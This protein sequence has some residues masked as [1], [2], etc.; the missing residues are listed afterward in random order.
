MNE[1]KKLIVD[2]K[3]FLESNDLTNTP[4][5]QNL[6]AQYRQKIQEFNEQAEQCQK[7][8]ERNMFIEAEQ[9]ASS[10]SK[11][12]FQQQKI[13]DFLHKEEFEELFRMYEWGELPTLRC[14]VLDALKNQQSEVSELLPLLEMYRRVARSNDDRTKIMLLRKITRIDTGKTEWFN[15]LKALENKRI[16]TLTAE[17]K[18]AIIGKDYD[19]LEVIR[20]ELVSPGWSVSVNPLV[21]GK[22]AAVLQEKHEADLK[23]QAESYINN[24]NLAYSAQDYAGLAKA[25]NTW[26]SFIV[27]TNYQPDA[28]QLA[29]YK[30]AERYYLEQKSDYEQKQLA[31]SLLQQLEYGIKNQINHLELENVYNQLRSCDAEIPEEMERDF[32]EYHTAAEAASRRKTFL[33]AGAAALGIII[34][35]VIIFLICS[36]LIL[37]HQEKKWFTVINQSL[38]Q[39][40]SADTLSIIETLKT[41]YPRIAQRERILDLEKQTLA[42]QAQERLN[43]VKFKRVAADQRE[44][45]KNFIANINR[46]SKNRNDMRLLI[47][48]QQEESVYNQLDAVYQSEMLKL[49]NQKEQKYLAVIEQIKAG[50]R[51]F[52]VA[53]SEKN[54][55]QA[56]EEIEKVERLKSGANA[57]EGISPDLLVRS[58]RVLAATVEMN[59]LLSAEKE[60]F[61]QISSGLNRIYDAASHEALIMCINE[62]V[63]QY[64]EHP[65]VGRIKNLQEFMKNISKF[66]AGAENA[67]GSVYRS[68]HV[69][70]N[71]ILTNSKNILA[72][73]QKTFKDLNAFYTKKSLGCI[74]VSKMG[75]P[76]EFYYRKK[77]GISMPSI[78]D[79]QIGED[80]IQQFNFFLKGKQEM[81]VVDSL[82]RE[83]VRGIVIYPN[84]DDHSTDKDL[85]PHIKFVN[86]YYDYL[87]NHQSKYWET[88]IADGLRKCLSDK[89]IAPQ[90]KLAFC[91][92]IT[93]HVLAEIP[94]HSIYKDL[95][96]EL[97]KIQAKVKEKPYNWLQSYKEI[98]THRMFCYELDTVLEKT[99]FPTDRESSF[100]YQV[101]SEAL[102]R[103]LIPVGYCVHNDGK[104]TLKGNFSLRNSGELWKASLTPPYFTIV[105]T[106]HGDQIKLSGKAKLASYQSL[107]TPADEQNSAELIKKYKNMAQEAKVQ[108][109]EWPATWPSIQE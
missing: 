31:A 39:K 106:F 37:K 13:L 101:L 52:Y 27:R 53:L 71:K 78:A 64:P 45:Y 89:F 12:L 72:K 43:R 17:A 35:G 38:K 15:S 18:E 91:R 21:T 7:L 41:K 48:D 24:V 1:L 74:I 83:I 100:Y 8:L 87:K 55:K 49:K 59:L 58:R 4:Y 23:K 62:F 63:S 57:F 98:S 34:S 40:P 81:T 73:L 30:E 90:M 67:G 51:K 5:S 94:D 95:S 44:L 82:D 10:G 46:I 88:A 103:K 29:Q 14:E 11:P 50:S 32:F 54:F 61:R 108:K 66:T 84:C 77:K 76:Y 86:W 69:R 16:D 93:N 80:M 102:N 75:D 96:L 20:D 104:Y 65:D 42:K 26:Q 56:E 33:I 97:K 68:D 92:M 70:R 19:K 107:F 60:K 22:I 28:V 6:A 9:L 105:G 3:S 79:C 85:A 47:V 109:I 99:P 36:T 2:I 25:V